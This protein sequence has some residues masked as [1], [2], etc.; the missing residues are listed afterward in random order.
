L[1]VSLART[2]FVP[3]AAVAVSTT[4][5]SCHQSDSIVLVEVAGDLSLQ[6]VELQV[7][8]T[9]GMQTRSFAVPPHPGSAITLPA[10]F[11]VELGPSLTGPVQVSIVA[12]D[13]SGAVIAQ[14]ATTQENID[15]G[16]QTLITVT[17]VSG[18]PSG[19][20]AGTDAGG[21]P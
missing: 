10:S 6:P 3:L 5:G 2:L 20:D 21:D 8:V 18:T 19:V 15:V 9:A 13:A 11:S 17:I 14:G 7:A 12:T 1:N 16:G 4:L